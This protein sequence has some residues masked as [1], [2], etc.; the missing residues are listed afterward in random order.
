MSDESQ[1]SGHK[2]YW[3]YYYGPQYCLDVRTCKRDSKE[4]DG[5]QMFYCI[6]KDLWEKA[7]ETHVIAASYARD[8]EKENERL[9]KE[10]EMKSGEI[11]RSEHRG[12]TVDYIYD[13]C[14]TYGDQAREYY[15]K[16]DKLT[17]ECARLAEVLERI[18]N[19]NAEPSDKYTALMG[20]PQYAALELAFHRERMKK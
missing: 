5:A 16:C 1:P 17:A 9:K 10:L 3:I 14:K 19:P 7:I 8:L 15:L 12:N 6:E 18:A 20:A 13:K 2:E 4:I 11:G